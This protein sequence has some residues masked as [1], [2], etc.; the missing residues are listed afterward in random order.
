MKSQISTKYLKK[1]KSNLPT[2]AISKIAERLNISQST[3][4]RVFNGEI[5]NLNVVEDALLLIKETEEKTAELE[6]KINAL[7]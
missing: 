3:V 4:S 1:L 2:G 6:S 7:S 5:K